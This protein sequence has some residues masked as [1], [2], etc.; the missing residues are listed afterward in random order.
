MRLHVSD[1]IQYCQRMPHDPCLVWRMA[2]DGPTELR[3]SSRL[4]PLQDGEYHT[5]DLSMVEAFLGA[6]AM[7]YQQGGLRGEAQVETSWAMDLYAALAEWARE[8][9]AVTA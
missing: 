4:I 7:D 8:T 6:D 9:D 3:L 1:V 2:P 5:D